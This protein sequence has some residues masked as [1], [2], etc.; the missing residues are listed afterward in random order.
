M[1]Y[2]TSVGGEIRIDPPLTW[3]EFRTSPFYADD[4]DH[5]NVALHVVEKIITTDDGELTCRTATALVPRWEDAFR[6]YDLVKHVQAAIDAFPGHAFTGRLE[7]EGEETGDLWR[8]VVRD[9]RAVKVTP[10]IVWP[11]DPE[12]I[13]RAA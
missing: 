12:P 11:D 13:I 6:A 4:T 1:G 7:C 5:Q 2:L 8:V 10:R 9:G 3:G